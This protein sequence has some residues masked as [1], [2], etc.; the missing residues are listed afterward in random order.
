MGFVSVRMLFSFSFSYGNDEVYDE[1]K[2]RF[3]KIEIKC[4]TRVHS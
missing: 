2:R 4:D 3:N 1:T